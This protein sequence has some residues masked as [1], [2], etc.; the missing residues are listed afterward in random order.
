VI[1]NE[2]SLQRQL[3]TF[4]EGG[5]TDF[6]GNIFDIPGEPESAQRAYEALKSLVGKV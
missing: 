1:G 6:V 2:T 3:E 4:A 5:A